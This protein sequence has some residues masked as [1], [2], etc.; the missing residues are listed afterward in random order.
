MHDDH[1]VS[2]R[3]AVTN[4]IVV[5]DC[6]LSARLD[7]LQSVPRSGRSGG[8]NH[9]AIARIYFNLDQQTVAMHLILKDLTGLLQVHEIYNKIV[10]WLVSL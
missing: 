5:L 2:S 7:P 3:S 9:G 4:Q 10:P 6:F 1:L 8:C